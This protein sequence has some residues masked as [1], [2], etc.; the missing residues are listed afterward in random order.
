[1]ILDTHINSIKPAPSLCSSAFVIPIRIRFRQPNGLRLL[2]CWCSPTVVWS[3]KVWRRTILRT[4]AFAH[5][6]KTLV[7]HTIYR[8]TVSIYIQYT[9]WFAQN[10]GDTIHKVV[11]RINYLQFKCR[12]FDKVFLKR[13]VQHKALLRLR[14]PWCAVFA[15][16]A[17]AGVVYTRITMG[18]PTCDLSAVAERSHG[19]HPERYICVKQNGWNRMTPPGWMVFRFVL[20]LTE[21][22]AAQR[23]LIHWCLHRTT[24]PGA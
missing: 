2:L 21:Y 1:M 4:S 24:D 10:L 23:T 8:T 17:N 22:S 5:L 6:N 14:Q 12:H 11:G 16:G 20:V 3:S 9:T 13:D 18:W 15:R 7:R 19:P